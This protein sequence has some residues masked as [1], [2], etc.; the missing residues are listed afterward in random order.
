MPSLRRKES[1]EVE[2]KPLTLFG[3]HKSCCS[4]FWL[5]H[6]G[7]HEA[8]AYDQALADREETPEQR[9][10]CRFGR[11]EIRTHDHAQT[12]EEGTSEK[13]RSHRGSVRR[14]RCRVRHMESDACP[15][16]GGQE[17]A[18]GNPLVAG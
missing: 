18:E 12:K 14:R 11:D 1:G 4:T 16:M 8:Q 9:Q 5:S 6:G 7:N 2:P 17:A 13:C 10:S 15:L 3:R